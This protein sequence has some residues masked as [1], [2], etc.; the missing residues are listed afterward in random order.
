MMGAAAFEG[1]FE[2]GRYDPTFRHAGSTSVSGPNRGSPTRRRTIVTMPTHMT[3]HMSVQTSIHTPRHMSRHTADLGLGRALWPF[4]SEA[5]VIR[6]VHR[7]VCRPGC[8]YAYTHAYP[9]IMMSWPGAT[10]TAF[11]FVPPV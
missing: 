8:R 11:E 6:H 3:I 9:P 7:Y 1:L 4:N 10:S 5:C 2:F